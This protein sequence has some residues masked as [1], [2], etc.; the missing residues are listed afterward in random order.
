MRALWLHIFRVLQTYTGETPLHHFLKAY[1]KKEPKLGSRDRKAISAAVYAWYRVGKGIGDGTTSEAHILAALA[2]CGEIPKPLQPKDDTEPIAPLSPIEPDKIISFD[3]PLSAGMTREAWAGSIVR[4]PRLFLRIRMNKTEISRRLGNAGIPFEWITE[5]CLALPN[6]TR[7]EDMLLPEWY[8][9][10]DIASQ[11]T[12][13]FLRGVHG[14]AWWDCCSGA[15]GKSLLL[16]DQ[17]PGIRLL[18]TDIRATIL[19]NLRDR[20]AQYKLSAP[21]TMVVDAADAEAAANALRG[22]RFEGIICDV[23]CTG[24]G[25]WARTPEGLFFFN[26]ETIAGYADRQG[27]ILANAAQRLKPGGRLI[28]ITCSVFRAENEDVIAAIAPG[29]GLETVRGGLINRF[30]AGGDALFAMELRKLG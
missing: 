30:A 10:Q 23:P 3:T 25:T 26:P 29:A 20:F 28:Y 1:F 2:Y 21:E 4:Q 17:S 14:E 7:V 11:E 13:P 15:G 16:T 24:S 18:A 19:N 8:V 12:G 27:R 9:I 5:H 22:R 6:G